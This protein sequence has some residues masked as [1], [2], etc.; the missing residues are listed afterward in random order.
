MHFAPFVPRTDLQVLE[1]QLIKGCDDPRLDE[2][3]RGHCLLCAKQTTRD[4]CLAAKAQHWH[5]YAGLLVHRE[6]ASTPHSGQQ[7]PKQRRASRE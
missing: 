6:H 7:L 2:E 4:G 5:G 1:H 3:R